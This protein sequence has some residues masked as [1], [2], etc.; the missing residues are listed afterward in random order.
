M[1]D[2][3]IDEKQSFIEGYG[4]TND[5]LAGMTHLMRAF[6]IMNYATQIESAIDK[7]DLKALNEFKLRLSGSLDLFCL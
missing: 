7:D 3:S 4:C 2:L 1:H 6:N 5:Q